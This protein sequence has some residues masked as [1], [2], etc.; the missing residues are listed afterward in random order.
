MTL[1]AE[2]DAVQAFIRERQAEV[3]ASAIAD[4][5]RA[6]LVE[7][8]AALHTA[9]GTVG[10]YQLEAAH[11]AIAEARAVAADPGSSDDEVERARQTALDRLT[12][13]ARDLASGHA[14]AQG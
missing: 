5:Q 11:S 9:D 14:Q 2:S 12:T 10:S 7:L 8:R 6:P 4:I 1:G 13:L 3:L